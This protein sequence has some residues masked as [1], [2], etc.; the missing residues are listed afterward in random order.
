MND[1]SSVDT[2]LTSDSLRSSAPYTTWNGL[3]HESEVDLKLTNDYATGTATTAT[4][5]CGEESDGEITGWAASKA[6]A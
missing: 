2:L 5:L 3:P 4:T 6:L 1:N